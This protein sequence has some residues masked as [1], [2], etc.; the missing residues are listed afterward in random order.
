MGEEGGRGEESGEGELVRGGAGAGQHCLLL[1]LLAGAGQAVGPLPVCLHAAGLLV[2]RQVG[3]QSKAFATFGA[4][5][6]FVR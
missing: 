2:F 3:F 6:W 4:R 1:H 5:E